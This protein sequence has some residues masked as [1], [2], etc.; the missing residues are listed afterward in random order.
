MNNITLAAIIT[1]AFWAVVFDIIAFV[2]WL[3]IQ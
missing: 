2:H 1:F 3:G